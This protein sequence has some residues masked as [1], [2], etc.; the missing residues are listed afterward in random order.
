[1]AELRHGPGERPWQPGEQV[2]KTLQTI[3]PEAL[4]G[5]LVAKSWQPFSHDALVSCW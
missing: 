3:A 1:M 5:I 2:A 4:I